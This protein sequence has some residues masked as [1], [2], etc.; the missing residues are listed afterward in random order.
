MLPNLPVIQPPNCNPLTQC[1]QLTSLFWNFFQHFYSNFI[2]PAPQPTL[3]LHPQ[4]A[5][6]PLVCMP[7]SSSFLAPAQLL[8]VP[9]I[10]FLFPCMLQTPIH[11]LSVSVNATSS[12]EPSFD[13]PTSLSHFYCTLRP[14]HSGELEKL[15]TTSQY[16]FSCCSPKIDT[17][18]LLASSACYLNMFYISDSDQ[19]PIEYSLWY[20]GKSW[21]NLCIS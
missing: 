7:A 16:C 21:D 8:S 2:N 11:P 13:P 15:T 6:L 5:P 1:D 19:C 9:G 10:V 18:V 14:W 20:Y 4:Q 17:L 12:E 3:L